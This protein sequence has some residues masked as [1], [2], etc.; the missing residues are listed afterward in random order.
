MRENILIKCDTLVCLKLYVFD[1]SVNRKCQLNYNLKVQNI[2]QQR[3]GP[4]PELGCFIQNLSIIYL[5]IL[6]FEL[7]RTE[8]EQDLYLLKIFNVTTFV[9]AISRATFC[10]NGSMHRC[11]Q[12]VQI[13][14]LCRFT[15]QNQTSSQLHIVFPPPPPFRIPYIQ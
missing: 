10:N 13:L 15:Y 4:R 14:F 3:Q 8:L 12:M 5:F 9:N 11:T 2:S 7:S 6:V 1:L